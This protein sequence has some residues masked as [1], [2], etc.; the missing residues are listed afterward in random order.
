MISVIVAVYNAEG[1]IRKCL[2]SLLAQ[3]YGDFEVV[4]VDDASTDSSPSIIAEYVE[5]DSRFHLLRMEKNVGQAVARNRG[6]DYSTGDIVTALDADDWFDA[7]SLRGIVDTFKQYPETDCAVFRCMMA[8]EDGRVEEY[9]GLKFD[10]LSGRDAA[11]ESLTWRI[12][13]YYATRREFYEQYPYDTTCHLYSDDNTTHVH[14]YL[15]RQVRQSRGRYYYLQHPLS[16]THRLSMEKMLF[17]EAADSL[18]R[19]LRE[20]SCDEQ[21][22]ME[23]E[24]QRWKIVVDCYYYYYMHR[25]HFSPEERKYCLEKIKKG[26][27][28]A[29][30]KRI[31]G[32]LP[33]K[34]GYIPFKHCWFLF[35]MEEELYF[36]LRGLLHKN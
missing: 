16:A 31:K 26:W 15:S 12:H 25:D 4:C 24:T 23:A 30:T 34:L 29:D 8:R 5:K 7:D 27:G 13:G 20:L 21:M 33:Y 14:Y 10:V 17:M 2:D 1:Y 36:A 6:I 35:R 11:Y 19:Q 9:D 32:T 3:T 18:C 22:M 28:S